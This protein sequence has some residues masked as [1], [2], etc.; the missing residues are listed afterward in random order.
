MEQNR[1]GAPRCA[2]GH[3]LVVDYTIEQVRA[4]EVLEFYCEE[5]DVRWDA[6]P[7]ERDAFLQ[8]LE[9]HPGDVVPS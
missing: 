9:S 6:S 4:L 3:L 8:Y 5:C 7:E 2:R 1:I